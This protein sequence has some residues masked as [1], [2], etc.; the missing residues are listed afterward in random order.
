MLLWTLVCMYL[1]KLKSSLDICP[2]V[3]LFSRNLH[4][5]FHSDCT[6]L[7]SHQQCRKVSFSS[8]PLQHLSFADFLMMVI[9]TGVSRYLIV[10]ICISLIISDVEHLFMCILAICMSLEKCLFRSSSHFFYWVV[11]FVDIELHELFINFGV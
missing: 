4:T 9:L 10:L 3:G 7:Y 8:H 11:C 2:G 5:V 6:N 1:F